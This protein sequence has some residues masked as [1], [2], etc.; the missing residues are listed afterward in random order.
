MGHKNYD[1]IL[2]HVAKRSLSPSLLMH[3]LQK[4][5]EVD[6][7]RDF[8]LNQLYGMPGADAAFYIPAIV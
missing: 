5:Y 7:V 2:K 6:G 8:L 3:Y 1:E 4:H